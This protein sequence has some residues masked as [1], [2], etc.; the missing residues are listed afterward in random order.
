MKSLADNWAGQKSGLVLQR[1]LWRNDWSI[2][3]L[4]HNWQHIMS[5]CAIESCAV[6][7]TTPSSI[8]KPGEKYNLCRCKYQGRFCLVNESNDIYEKLRFV[9]FCSPIESYSLTIKPVC[10]FKL[11]HAPTRKY[12]EY[13]RSYDAVTLL[14]SFMGT[15]EST[16]LQVIE[17]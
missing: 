12:Y 6:S 17:W 3:S 1:G 2:L 7:T 16:S 10:D 13:S 8:L 11:V 4:Y 14:C 5:Y 15:S 9:I